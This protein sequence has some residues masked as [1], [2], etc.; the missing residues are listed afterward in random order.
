MLRARVL[1]KSLLVTS[2][3]FIFL[4]GPKVRCEE[5]DASLRLAPHL[6][7]LLK[8]A[9]GKTE[10]FTLHAE[11]QMPAISGAAGTASVTIGRADARHFYASVDVS[12]DMKATLVLSPEQLYVDLPAKNV[13]FVA[14][15]KLPDGAAALKPDDIF[16]A[17]LRL[18]PSAG[19]IWTIIDDGGDGRNIAVACNPLLHATLTANVPQPEPNCDYVTLRPSNAQPEISL[20]LHAGKVEHW[21]ATWA[22]PAMVE[23]TTANIS[24]TNTL[25]VSLSSTCVLPELPAGRKIIP[26]SRA[27]LERALQ[28]GALRA[29][30]I[31]V[32]DLFAEQPANDLVEIPGARLEIRNGQRTCWLSGTPYDMGFQHGK[33]LG[34]EARRVTDSTLYVVGMYYSVSQGKWFLNE[35]RDA[36]ARLE[37]HCDKEYLDELKGLAA[38]S[39]IA[40]DEIKLANVFPELF[41]CSGFAIS[42]EA[43]VGGKLYHGRVLDYMTDIGLQHVQVDFITRKEGCQGYVNIGYAGFVGCVSGMNESQISLGEMGGKGQGNWDGIPMAFLMRKV[44]ERSKTL[45]DARAIFENA[46]RT[47]EYYYV[48]ADGKTRSALG[49]AAWPDKI[50]FIKQGETNPRLPEAL[51]GCVLLSA[52]QRYKLLVQRTKDGFGKIDESAAIKLM[53][54]PVSMNGNLHSVLFVPEDQTYYTAHASYRGHQP[55][56]TQDYVKHNLKAALRVLPDLNQKLAQTP[57]K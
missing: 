29:I 1:S 33:L 6:D 21:T 32:D 24:K 53:A 18:N 38:G 40:E 28:R 35:I 34:R 45:E 13:A 15:G 57:P 20:A 2:V 52:D 50:E 7:E 39:A 9:K 22:S 55:A 48:I 19:A 14:D 26:V 49:V 27:E 30:D 44:L 37:P 11:G 46:K 5:A 17:L 36:W 54:R 25:D 47:C 43:T 31:R 41:H 16:H 56:S 4:A 51:P 8:I 10:V 23:K 3:F 12:K 42:G